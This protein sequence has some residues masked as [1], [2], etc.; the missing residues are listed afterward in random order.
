M[1]EEQEK[2]QQDTEST[3]KGNRVTAMH[4]KSAEE[5]SV[6]KADAK[7]FSDIEKL[8]N[9]DPTV[10]RKDIEQRLNE[11]RDRKLPDPD[12]EAVDAKEFSNAFTDGWKTSSFGSKFFEK[13]NP[14]K[15]MT[16]FDHLAY[17]SG[18][19]LGNMIEPLAVTMTAAGVVPAGAGTATVAA[20]GIATSAVYSYCDELYK[21]YKNGE[22]IDLS[23]AYQAL[24]KDGLASMAVLLTA[25]KLKP[26]FDS[27]EQLSA[28][29]AMI[30]LSESGKM[31]TDLGTR[32]AVEFGSGGEINREDFSIEGA[33][34][35]LGGGNYR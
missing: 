24:T 25:Q 1:R 3:A 29:E 30:L 21:Q 11:L 20:V 18:Q 33:K 9:G 8:K 17:G 10:D 27:L 12:K 15:D 26:F 14:R 32:L 4:K 22:K 28:K 23:K 6:A 5:A 16:T 13:P 35:I 19:L 7:L 34:A 2:I 31:L